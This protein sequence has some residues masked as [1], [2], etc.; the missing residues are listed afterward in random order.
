MNPIKPFALWANTNDMLDKFYKQP[1]INLGTSTKDNN[2]RNTMRHIVGPAL[3]TKEFGSNITRS[4]GALKEGFDFIE[5]RDLND[6]FI[7]FRNNNLG[8]DFIEKIQ[9]KQITKL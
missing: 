9:I 1:D 5:K 8:I 2:I 3:M 4:L 6:N 7:D